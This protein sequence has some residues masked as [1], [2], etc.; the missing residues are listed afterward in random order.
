MLLVEMKHT[1]GSTSPSDAYDGDGSFYVCPRPRIVVILWLCPCRRSDE[2]AKARANARQISL[3][4]LEL[5]YYRIVE[6]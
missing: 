2:P 6:G 3:V 4:D 5:R 1:A